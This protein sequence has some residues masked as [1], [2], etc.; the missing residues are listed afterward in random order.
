MAE[1]VWEVERM[2]AKEERADGIFYLVDW[3]GW[4]LDEASFA[5]IGDV[6]NAAAENPLSIGFRTRS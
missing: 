1:G 4:A 6:L 2:L 3:K 5:P